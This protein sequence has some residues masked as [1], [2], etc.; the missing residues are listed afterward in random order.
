NLPVLVQNQNIAR[1][2][3]LNEKIQVS[4]R[5]VE[6]EEQQEAMKWRR[7]DLITMSGTLEVPSEA[8]NFGAL[9][10]RTY[11]Y[12]KHIHLIV[13]TKGLDHITVNKPTSGERYSIA[14]LLGYVDLTRSYL[15]N[16][17]ER[18]FSE[19]SSGFMKSLLLGLSD[20]LETEYFELFAKFGL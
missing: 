17:L 10:Y 4:V 18:L 12:Y 7:G 14:H 2:Q 16:R 11:L 5:F 3:T 19:K 15:G 1:N 9:D 13:T 8:S 6:L 20:E